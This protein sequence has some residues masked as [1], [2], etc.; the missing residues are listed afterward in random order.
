MSLTITVSFSGKIYCIDQVL[1]SLKQISLPDWPVRW[2]FLD[3][4]ED[5]IVNQRLQAFERAC[6]ESPRDSQYIKVLREPRKSFPDRASV[7]NYLKSYVVGNWLSLS[8]DVMGYRSDLVLKFYREVYS[9]YDLAIVAASM[10]DEDTGVAAWQGIG[11]DTTPVKARDSGLTLVDYVHLDC[12]LIRPSV[13]I[14]SNFEVVTV[15]GRE[16]PGV[17]LSVEAKRRGL[18]VGV[19]WEV[20]ANRM[21]EEGVYYP[22]MQPENIARNVGLNSGNPLVSVITPTSGRPLFLSRLIK[23]LKEQSYP[24]FEHL[25]CNDGPSKF[26]AKLVVEEGDQRFR[27]YELGFR[28]GFS[29]APQRNYLLSRVG[30]DLVVFLDDDVEIFSD[31]LQTMV[32]LWRGGNLVGFCQV[33]VEGEG[34]EK[35]VIPESK[36]FIREIGHIDSMCGYVDS[37]IAK[38]FFWDLLDEHDARY[39]QQILSFTRGNCGFVSRVLGKNFRRYGAEDKVPGLKSPKELVLEISR[40][41]EKP[42]PEMEDMILQDPQAILQY[43]MN[44]LNGERWIRGEPVLAKD[45][46]AAIFYV[47]NVLRGRFPEA[48]M[49]FSGDIRMAI[50]YSGV[51]K[52]RWRDIGRLDVEDRIMHDPQSAV[53]YAVIFGVWPEAESC[54]KSRPEAWQR[55]VDTVM[56]RK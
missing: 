46:S 19:L 50:A 30:G 3:Y 29:G 43:V 24:V 52:V 28:H 55:Y 21:S 6:K 33:E 36:G 8:D 13:H 53:D 11:Q 27:Y 48:E 22:A 54:I 9:R 17:S 40:T 2:V 4:S 41:M 56:V 20:G 10:V 44:A 12:T 26:I 32:N 7:F 1:R 16:V 37:S 47:Q 31:Y 39:F 5:L 45:K 38:A 35:V 25:I 42:T 51:T 15:F 23:N 34:Q 18:S 14:G 49:L